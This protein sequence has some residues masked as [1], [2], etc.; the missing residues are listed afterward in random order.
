MEC[1]AVNIIW[2]ILHSKR[3]V[4][5]QL[6]WSVIQFTIFGRYFTAGGEWY[7]SLNEVCYSEHYV[8]DNSQQVD[9]AISALMECDRVNFMW[10]I[11]HRKWTVELQLEWNVLQ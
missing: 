1:V 2:K 8:E 9:S 10:K 7:C 11:L 6:E 5:L 3:T 4:V